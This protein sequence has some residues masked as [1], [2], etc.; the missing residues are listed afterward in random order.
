MLCPECKTELMVDRVE[1]KEG[2]RRYIFLCR[3]PNCPAFL[4]AQYADG[5]PATSTV[6]QQT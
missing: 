1:E 5:E 4:R 3:N 2:V 6:V